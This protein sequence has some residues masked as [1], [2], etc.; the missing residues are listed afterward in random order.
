VAD[1]YEYE[2]EVRDRASAPLDDITRAAKRSERELESMGKRAGDADSALKGMAGALGIIS[3]ELEMLVSRAGDALG[4]LE[5]LER[6]AEVA[7]GGMVALGGAAVAVTANVGL[8]A[9]G[10]YGLV[11]AALSATLAADELISE[12]VQPLN[13]QLRNVDAIERTR[14]GVDALDRVWQSLTLTLGDN[15]APSV[16]Q[17][18]RVLVAGGILLDR[19]VASISQ[20]VDLLKEGVVVLSSFAAGGTVGNL[21]REFVGGQGALSVTTGVR[22]MAGEQLADT[23]EDVFAEADTLIKS[24]RQASKAQEDSA[25]SQGSSAKAM[26]SASRTLAQIA[27]SIN[28]APSSVTLEEDPYGPLTDPSFLEGIP[29]GQTSIGQPVAFTPGAGSNTRGSITT[30]QV[31]EAIVSALGGLEAGFTYFSD[32]LL[33]G[34]LSGGFWADI[35]N[36][37]LDL[38]EKG[39]AGIEQTRI[40]INSSLDGFFTDALPGFLG[41]TLSKSILG[42]TERGGLM[43]RIVD[44]V[45]E[46]VSAITQDLIPSLIQDFLPALFEGLA[47]IF[48]LGIDEGDTGGRIA[49]GFATSGLSEIF[50]GLSKGVSS[51]YSMG[52]EI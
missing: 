13:A 20:N 1:V 35:F 11:D 3:P 31:G 28:F 45:P 33:S 48:T 16:E 26:G 51:G 47:N 18:V 19:T 5:G 36:A 22:G 39:A 52:S 41:D 34:R 17:V 43:G 40:D 4:G 24:M 49:A 50:R 44:A 29:T 32:T 21:V 37:F 23:F 15:V 12:G 27:D 9:A 30:G 38:G 25:K 10:L 42:F 8:F 2:V 6:G 14:A 7:G 46:I